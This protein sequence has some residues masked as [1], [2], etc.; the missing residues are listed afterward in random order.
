ML[1]FL[2]FACK[3]V[4]P[5]PDDLNGLIHYFWDNFNR[6]SA[7]IQQGVISI[8]NVLDGDNLSE[9]MDGSIRNLTQQ[10]TELVGKANSDVDRL[11]GVFF[12]NVINC[13][14]ASVEKN[15]YA[16][17]QPELHPDSYEA[18]DR[19]YTS[20]LQAYEARE[21][22]V[23][24]WETN[25]SVAGFGYAYDAMVYGDLR[26]V[27]PTEE[28]PFGP[29]LLSRTILSEPAYFDA[30]DT[31]RGM[32]QDFQLELYYE[33]KPGETMHVYAIWR[34]MVMAGSIDFS[35]TSSQR[36]VLDGLIDWDI[37]LENACHSL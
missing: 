36:L 2:F 27:T 26:Y 19:T 1:F 28:S 18:Y 13:P 23:L 5:A 7:V 10:Q 29:A 9:V 15:I 20:D 21:E 17:N 25:Y 34:E 3:S 32:F 14:L 12:T 8:H 30:D 35:S 33:R 24:R 6:E 31:D 11:S 22:E 37:D 4:E 16:L